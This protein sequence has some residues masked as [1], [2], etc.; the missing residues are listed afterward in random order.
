[1]QYWEKNKTKPHLEKL[2]EHLTDTFNRTYVCLF[3]FTFFRVTGTRNS[4]FSLRECFLVFIALYRCKWNPFVAI[5]TEESFPVICLCPS[6][7]RR[8]DVF[9]FQSKHCGCSIQSMSQLRCR[10]LKTLADDLWARFHLLKQ[11]SATTPGGFKH[12]RQTGG[13]HL[14]KSTSSLNN[15]AMET[16]KANNQETMCKASNKY[17][18]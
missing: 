8:P 3:L 5:G 2:L 16:G 11:S 7:R 13:A 1:M 18:T 6:K 10:L 15:M 9:N 12:R 4:A 14:E 17:L